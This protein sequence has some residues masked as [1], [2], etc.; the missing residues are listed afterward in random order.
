MGD[1]LCFPRR[2]PM[3]RGDLRVPDRGR[4]HR[5]RTWSVPVGHMEPPARHHH[6]GDNGD[7]ACDHY[8][9]LESDVDL[10]SDLS[11]RGYRF[12]VAWPRRN[13]KRTD[14]S[15]RPASTTTGAC[16]TSSWLKA[17]SRW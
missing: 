16:S 13:Q 14:A 10:I 8:H 6:R 7:I 1:R 3:G 17:S 4:G 2:L 5:G 15:T 12:S 11:L 9:R